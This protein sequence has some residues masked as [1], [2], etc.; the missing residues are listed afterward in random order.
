MPGFLFKGWEFD[1]AVRY[2]RTKRKNGGIA[3]IAILSYIGVALAIWPICRP[4]C[5]LARLWP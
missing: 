5:T 2:L 1:L 3:V 4:A